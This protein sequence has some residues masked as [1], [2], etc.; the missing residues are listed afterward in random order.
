MQTKSTTSKMAISVKHNQLN[1]I[2]QILLNEYDALRKEEQCFCTTLQL[3]QESKE[4]GRESMAR[5]K[6][7]REESSLRR[8]EAALMIDIG[9]RSSSSESSDIDGDNNK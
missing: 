4:M 5:E 1:K 7:E 3:K 2:E 6:R 8:L 9:D